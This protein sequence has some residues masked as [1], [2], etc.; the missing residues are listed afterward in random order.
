[1]EIHRRADLP[2]AANLLAERVI[3]HALAGHIPARRA[4]AHHAAPERFTPELLQTFNNGP[5]VGEVSSSSCI[6]RHENTL[7]TLPDEVIP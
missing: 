6:G 2:V 5:D 7:A 3:G 4:P 1:V